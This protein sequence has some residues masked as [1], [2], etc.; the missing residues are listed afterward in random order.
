M[1]DADF[2]RR[3]REPNRK[4]GTQ[5]D[6]DAANAALIRDISYLSIHDK[7]DGMLEALLD[8]ARAR[9]IPFLPEFINT[10][11]PRGHK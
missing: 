11:E 6:M 4:R 8:I 3:S 2:I 7:K 10:I 1:S 5:A 9:N